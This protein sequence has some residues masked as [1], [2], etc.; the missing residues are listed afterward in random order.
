MQETNEQGM[1]L[2]DYVKS[3]NIT[4]EKFSNMTGISVSYLYKIQKD[5]D[6]NMMVDNI[7]RIYHAT[8]KEFGVGLDCWSYLNK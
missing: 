3:K 2:Y 6:V 5:R 7:R 4:M 1:T 8:E